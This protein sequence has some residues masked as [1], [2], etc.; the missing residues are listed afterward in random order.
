MERRQID[1]SQDCQKADARILGRILAAQN[2][3]FTLPYTSR[4]A[5]FYAR[6]LISIP[7]IEAC[8]VCLEG[9]SV[10]AGKMAT[11]SCEQC[12]TSFQSDEEAKT[13]HLPTSHFKCGL[14]DQPAMRLIAV[15]SNQHHF[16]FFVLKIHQNA[17][18][19]L[20]QP[21]I[22]NLAGYVALILENRWQ[23]KMLQKSRDELER[24]V[25][26]RTH[27]LNT[28]NEAMA[29]SKRKA[30]DTM[31]K[32][33][34]AQRRLEKARADL[35]RSIKGHK[36]VER[37]YRTLI[38]S[39]PDLIV[40]YDP[41]L[42][43]TYVNPAWEKLSGL[44]A[45][46]VIGVPYSDIPRVPNP[47]N[48]EYLEKLR[49]ALETGTTQVAEFT[50]VNAIGVTLFLEYVIVP[51]YDNDGGIVGVLAVGR[52]ITQRKRAEEAS[53]RMN[54]QLRAIS[55]CNQVLMQASVEQT[56]LDHIC[57]IVCEEA[58][59][60]MAW[61]GY[62]QKDAA[63]TIRPI[64]WAGSEEGYLAEAGITW[65]DTDH[66]RGPT[67]RALREGISACIQDFAS[68]PHAAPWRQS[69]LQRG[70]RS[71]IALPL[72]SESAPPFGVLCIY[73]AD[74][75]AF[76]P[77]EI[78]LLEELAG[79]LAFGITAL[80]LRAEHKEAEN[81]ILASEQ[82]FR[83]LVE[84]APDFIAR[85]DCEYRRIYVNPAIQKLFGKQEKNVLGRTPGD[86]SP[87]YAPQIYIDHLQQ[88]I[89]TAAEGTAEIPFR[90]A[91]G[92]MHWGQIRFVPEF[93]A[94]D[95][96]VSV[97]TIGRDIHEIKENETRF[98]MLAENFPDLV[99]RFDT[100]G[101]YTYV[102][103]AFEKTFGLPA[104]TITGKSLRELPKGRKPEKNDALL[105]LIHRA[106]EEG[107]ANESEVSWGTEMG[108]RLYEIRHAPERDAT[109]NVVSVLS[110]ARDITERKQADEELARYKA[111]LEEM[112]RSRTAELEQARN[113]ARQYLDIAGVILVAIDARRRVTLI[114]Q[115]GCEILESTADEIIG[116]DW[117][118]TFIPEKV[119]PDVIRGFKHLMAGEKALVQYF[120]NPVLTRSGRLRLVAWHN[121]QL[122]DDE[123]RITGT[124]SSGED[125]TQRRQSEKQI[126]DLNH[127]LQKRAAELE[128]ANK[129]LDAFAYSV[130]HDL[131]APLR[132]IDGFIELLRKR[133]EKAQDKLSRHYMDTI[134]G[135][136]RRMGR[137]IDD[138]LSF[139]RMGRRAMSSQQVALDEMVKDV[140]QELASDAAGRAIDWQIG[141]LPMV[142]GD[143]T[144]LSRVLANL[145]GNALKFTRPRQKTRIE[146]GSLPDQDSET[147]IFV[148]DNGVGFNMAYVDKLFGVFQRLHHADEFEGT[149]IGLANVHRIIARHGGRVW[150][151][152][153][154]DQG[155]TFYFAL[156]RKLQGDE[157]ERR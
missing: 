136:A 31:K 82:L 4:I 73:A 146:I 65:A 43:R 77:D 2:V 139:S 39:V 131:R 156:P 15:E 108:E 107:V 59:Y 29:A 69:A 157:N 30:I 111:H 137:L 128:T 80:R 104:D 27:D 81:K 50:W 147:V 114:N 149:G 24:R 34:K 26:E 74:P 66:G 103:P 86:Q 22:S 45:A 100:D 78:R 138:L 18:G 145:I 53:H 102:N 95:R 140:I 110:I 36:Q 33:V 55:T 44:P 9:S 76:T 127:N 7:G 141:D 84:N 20:Y 72:R 112:V 3:V 68:D 94:D 99:A 79:N 61:V 129:E 117:F 91:Q 40:R 150:A 6:I 96:V 122:K 98:R 88:A 16:G 121:V 118:E 10:P 92:E 38:E 17:V 47:V 142:S 101:R 37:E 135:S 97:L 125:I 120:E 46:E 42:R 51:E 154:Q 64:A 62:P 28:A 119:R 63:R 52:D 148:R 13:H 32:A 106:F 89:E 21:F 153:V 12:R 54:R 151:E 85:Y 155:A 93:D 75:N 143:A 90:T 11:A 71:S 130:S 115:K 48:A 35:E 19:E 57:R 132:H 41:G 144:M 116:K 133:A 70:Y 123:G 113:K 1:P 109:G 126:I 87:I 5:E 83:A 56:L 60:R 8:R 124:L 49:L 67:G 58:G 152:S 105:S 14:A 25:V 134:S 23:K